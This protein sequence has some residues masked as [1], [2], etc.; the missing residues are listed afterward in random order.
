MTPP[1][2]LLSSRLDLSVDILVD[3]LSFHSLGQQEI[4]DFI[5]EGADLIPSFINMF[6]VSEYWP[7]DSKSN[8]S[9]VPMLS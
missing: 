5:K 6:F 1:A 2:K 8:F 3:H 4:F 9:I 7:I